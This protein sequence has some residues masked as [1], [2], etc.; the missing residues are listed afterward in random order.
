M[1]I[2]EG[3]TVGWGVE[4]GEE[5]GSE[6]EFPRGWNWRCMMKVTTGVGHRVGRNYWLGPFGVCCEERRWQGF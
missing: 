2:L 5:V 3:R 4:W 1:V 6:V